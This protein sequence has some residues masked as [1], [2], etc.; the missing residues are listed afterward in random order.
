MA[1]KTI[2]FNYLQFYVVE[3][4]QRIVFEMEEILNYILVNKL[5]EYA[6]DVNLQDKGEI[7]S[8]TLEYKDKDKLF[9]FQMSKLRNQNIPDKKKISAVREK[10]PLDPNEYLSEYISFIFDPQF[11]LSIVQTN[12]NSLSTKE[13]CT[14]LHQLRHMYLVEKGLEPKIFKV[15]ADIVPDSNKIKEV[16]EA[17]S[18]RKITLKGAE[19]DLASISDDSSLREISQVINQFKG[20]NFEISISVEKYA[21]PEDTLNKEE[22]NDLVDEIIHGNNNLAMKVDMKEDSDTAI[23]TVNLVEPRM[24]SYIKLESNR[25]NDLGIEVIY[26]NFMELIYNEQRAKLHKIFKVKK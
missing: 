22:T 20:V 21:K 14:Y 25:N 13:I 18:I 2:R 15:E 19:I 6:Y 17:D 11:D 16:K 7:D 8:N 24:T 3:N 10:L 1:K 4:N 23:E 26:T 12:R 5:K 9:H